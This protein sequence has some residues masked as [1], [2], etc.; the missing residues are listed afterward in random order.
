[1]KTKRNKLIIFTVILVM[2][3]IFVLPSI[4][5]TY[6]SPSVCSAGEYSDNYYAYGYINWILQR[7]W[8]G[9]KAT[10]ANP[11]P[12]YS[13][14][15][16]SANHTIWVSTNSSADSWVEAGYAKGWVIN[17]I[18]Y[19]NVRTLYTARV[20]PN[21]KYDEHRVTNVPVGAPGT[22]HSYTILYSGG[23]RWKVYIDGTYVSYSDQPPYSK[24]IDVG[25]ESVDHANVCREVYP[26]NMSYCY[27]NQGWYSFGQARPKIYTSDSYYHFNYTNSSK[28]SGVDYNDYY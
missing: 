3:G 8:I 27:E 23:G 2:I 12:D 21:G 14:P 28:D 19:P 11:N 16:S 22:T 17:G 20:L 25:L 10:F 9:G 5:S 13:T 1:M 6:E 4:K 18:L 15:N 24:E 7:K 26:T